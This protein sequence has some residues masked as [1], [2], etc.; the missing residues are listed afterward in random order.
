M[1]RRII[2]VEER[3]WRMVDK[4]GDEEC[5]EWT[6][7]LDSF[8]YG[9]IK[10]EKP[11]GGRLIKAHRLS[12]RIHF[13]DIPVGLYVL[14]KCDNRKCVNPNHFFLGTYQDN[15]DDM[16]KK[17][18]NVNLRGSKI[19]TSRFTESEIVEI[20]TDYFVN[21]MSTREISVKYSVNQTYVYQIIHGTVWGHVTY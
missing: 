9:I 11:R 7:A 6:G 10:D 3:F 14:H 5:W 12:H 20:K 19:G 16:Y 2:P 13:G 15:S 8:G 1:P 21:K 4:K 18:R 17:G